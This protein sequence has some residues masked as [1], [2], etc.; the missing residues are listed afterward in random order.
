MS[1]MQSNSTYGLSWPKRLGAALAV[2]VFVVGVCPA[3]ALVQAQEMQGAGEQDLA[4][5]G[6]LSQSDATASGGMAAID[7]LLSGIE[8]K[9][10]S[11][12]VAL[13]NV[14][15]AV[16]NEI[17]IPAE[18][19]GI[20][21]DKRAGVLGFQMGGSESEAIKLITEAMEEH[22]WRAIPLGGVTGAT[23]TKSTDDI[24]WA[25]ATCTQTGESVSVVI[26]VIAQAHH[27]L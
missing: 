13:D 2:V 1:A 7:A 11:A 8:K 9:A 4:L 16:R 23:F 10:N 20:R 17:A 24:A 27:P 5:G 15:Q 21:W 26:R 25:L 22:G 3:T 19:W 6:V 18:S 12:S 14:P